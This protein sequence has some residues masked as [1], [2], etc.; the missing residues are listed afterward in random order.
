MT[1][2]VRAIQELVAHHFGMSREMLLSKQR[3]RDICRPRQMA[4]KL[5]RD[6]T[7][8]SLPRIGK[9]FGNM[10]HT[11]IMHGCRRIA[12]LVEERNNMVCADFADLQQKAKALEPVIQAQRI[13][14]E[15]KHRAAVDDMQPHLK[16]Q[17]GAHVLAWRRERARRKH[18][19][20]I[21]SYRKE[22]AHE[23]A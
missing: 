8:R 10:D 19:S 16:G 14:A 4:M 3:T 2:S 9:D 7:P 21:R 13:A 17:H 5:A 11:T 18:L 20:E 6:L 1:D 23:A 22:S 15:I 12:Q